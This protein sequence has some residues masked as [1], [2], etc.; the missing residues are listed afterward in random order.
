MAAAS[1]VIERATERDAEELASQIRMD[2][3]L[4]LAADTGAEP[5]AVLLAALGGNTWALRIGGEVAAIFGVTVASSL[6]GTASAWMITSRA[7]ER[8]P[9]TFW[10]LCRSELPKLLERFGSL[11]NFI[12]AR[13]TRALRWARRLGFQISEPQPYGA[14][15]LPFHRFTVT[16]EGLAC[17][18]R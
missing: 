12:D 8:H 10:K 18:L 2:D 6:G 5:L 16:R 9:V 17:A 7:V 14:L 3:A 1:V 15:G 13:H 4:E 11:W